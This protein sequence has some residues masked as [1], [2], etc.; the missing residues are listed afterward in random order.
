VG[1]GHEVIGREVHVQ[2][3]GFTRGDKG[4]YRTFDLVTVKDGTCSSTRSRP[5]RVRGIAGGSGWRTGGSASLVAS[6]M[7][8][9]PAA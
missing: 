5:G 4:S 9:A 2:V 7:G 6:R 1:Q 3:A 8:L